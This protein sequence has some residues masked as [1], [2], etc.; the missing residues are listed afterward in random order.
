MPLSKGPQ[1]KLYVRWEDLKLLTKKRGEEADFVWTVLFFSPV[2]GS[3]PQIP[4]EAGDEGLTTKPRLCSA[5]Q[6]L[7]SRLCFVKRYR[8][9]NRSCLNMLF[10]G[11]DNL[12][13]F[14][15]FLSSNISMC[16]INRHKWQSIWMMPYFKVTSVHS[17]LQS[18]HVVWHYFQWID[19]WRQNSKTLCL[20]LINC[21]AM[22]FRKCIRTR[23]WHLPEF[24]SLQAVQQ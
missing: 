10:S 1:L 13:T 22:E 3:L 6:I 20:T 18:Y 12:T 23:T 8:F 17:Q 21:C 14:H 5:E 19:I 7:D 9:Q 2:L 24:D 16:L 11:N 15:N 4:V